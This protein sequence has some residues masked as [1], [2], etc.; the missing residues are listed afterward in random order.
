MIFPAFPEAIW[1]LFVTGL[2]ALVA[3]IFVLFSKRNQANLF[4]VLLGLLVSLWC[5]LIG[6]MCSSTLPEARLLFWRLAIFV[7]TPIPLVILFFSTS[8]L[9]IR[10][11]K[12]IIFLIV[13]VFLPIQYF[14]VTETL[15]KSSYSNQDLILNL[16]P[17]AIPYLIY[18]LLFLTWAILNFY[19]GY[20]KTSSVERVKLPYFIVGFMLTYVIGVLFDVVFVFFG[21]N[22]FIYFGPMSSIFL[23]GFTAYAITKE[24]LMDIRVVIGRS[25]TYVL[26]GILLVASFVGLNA[27]PMPMWLTT[28]TNALLALTWAWAAHRLREF[29]QTPV[30]KWISWY[31]PEELLNSIVKEL[32]LVSE[33]EEAFKVIAAQLKSK[34]KIKKVDIL[35]GKRDDKPEPFEYE[36]LGK[37]EGR[38]KLFDSKHSFITNLREAIHY[39]ELNPETRESIKDVDFLKDGLY[40][41]LFSAEGLEGIIVL[42]QKVS[43][44]AY[45]KK[46]FIFFETLILQTKAFLDRIRPY[47]K[48]KK[49]FEANQKRLYDTERTL[50][51]SEKI[52]SLANLIREYNHE[53]KTP[54][55]IIR[56]NI[57]LLP[58]EPQLA[59]FKK[60]VVRAIRRADDI[61]ESTL[62]LG[63]PRERQE[64]E[65]DLNE[66]VDQAL[67]LFPPSGVHLVKELNPLPLLKGD[68]EDL[69]TVF[70]NLIKNSVEAMPQGGT[71]K[72]TTYSGIKD[73][74]PAVFASI[75]D[76][77][78]GI[79][80]ENVE[81]IFEPFFSTHVTKG[82]G[83]GLSIVFRIIREHLGRI[84][85]KSQPGQGAAFI[86]CFPVAS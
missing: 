62:R 26:I 15:F 52:A 4:F 33:R 54:L 61:V 86:V 43:E 25:T 37:G 80:K 16:G 34:I 56:N 49:E 53:I 45:N 6:L 79:P 65:L 9:E 13:L 84:E 50:A 57:A 40:L 30:D 70:V 36:L 68:K 64:V 42:G 67:K 59:E 44:D 77:G 81:K 48:I 22:K 17:L 24:E 19:F 7:C 73:D 72:V 78:V 41:P 60:I 21:Y 74:Q 71:L 14:S 55:A 23:V 51:R 1:I 39:N 47:E 2:L 83:L 38:P 12:S 63:E 8:F 27:L 66:I 18:Y 29:I 28:T 3:S 76:T 31:K 82:R 11:P 35:L 85:V 10:L 69:Q 58:D 32:G 20:R 5:I 75:S 46:D